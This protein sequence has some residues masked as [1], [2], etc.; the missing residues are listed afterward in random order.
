MKI[1]VT[2]ASGFVGKYLVK[3][4]LSHEHEVVALGLNN[5]NLSIPVYEADILDYEAVLTCMKQV[6]PDAVIHLAAISNVPLSWENPGLTIDVNIHGTTNVF[7]ALAEVNANG[8]FLSI[9][10]SDEY[11]L[12]AKAGVPLTE[13]MLCQPQNPY[14]I[15]KYCAEQ[16]VL[17]LGK[18]YNMKVIHTRSFNHFGPGQAKGFVTSDFACQIAAIEKGLREPIIRVG[19]LSAYRDFLYVEDVVKAYVALIEENV[20]CGIYNICSGK[21]IQMKTI[22]EQLLLQAKN[23][24][25][26]AVDPKKYRPAEVP[27]FVGDCSKLKNA[28]GWS[29]KISFGYGAELLLDYWRTVG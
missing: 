13:D 27:F 4:L 21:S 10:S 19:D 20:S 3:L 2:G 6:K 5:A 8:M 1:L 7:Q 11:G 18:K 14:A 15:S 24:I 25:E 26:I 22:L 29:S 23:K 17:Q 9:G 28:T 16:M 12:T